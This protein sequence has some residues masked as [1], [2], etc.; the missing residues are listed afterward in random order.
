M[1]T[2][3][4]GA[5]PKF[6]GRDILVVEDEEMIASV[7]EEMLLDLGCNQVW[8]AGNAKDAQAILAQHKPHAVILDVNLGGDSGYQL[9]Q[10]LADAKIAF[11]FATGYGRYGLPEQWAT[12]PIMQKPFKMDT[13][14][15]VLG[16]VL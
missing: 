11:I 16:A 8:V 1:S 15:A 6:S 13:L 2:Q 7:I 14:Q 9:A 3:R 12:R 10:K 5:D 4:L